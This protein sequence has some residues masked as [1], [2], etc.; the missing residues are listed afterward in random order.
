MLSLEERIEIALLA[1]N[2][3]ENGNRTQSYSQV[4]EQFGV[5]KQAV[6]Q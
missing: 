2:E 4:G 1:T 3:D 5:T 6:A